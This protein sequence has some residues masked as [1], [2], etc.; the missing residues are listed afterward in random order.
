LTPLG[1]YISFFTYKQLQIQ[2][3]IFRLLMLV[4]VFFLARV[5]RRRIVPSF[6]RSSATSRW[7]PT[8]H[9]YD[10]SIVTIFTQFGSCGLHTFS[11][12]QCIT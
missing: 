3:A 9:M 8:L 6:N 7:L 12:K 11:C 1:G 10:N 5:S 4:I 2:F